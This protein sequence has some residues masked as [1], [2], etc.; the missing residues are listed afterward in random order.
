M[1]DRFRQAKNPNLSPKQRQQAIEEINEISGEGKSKASAQSRIDNLDRLMA[2]AKD[3]TATDADR[4]LAEMSTRMG[5]KQPKEKVRDAPATQAFPNSPTRQE[6]ETSARRAK[7]DP[8]AMPDSYYSDIPTFED[9]F[10]ETAQ[11][12]PSKAK[13]MAR[14]KLTSQANEAVATADKLHGLGHVDDAHALYSAIPKN[15]LPEHMKEYNP[16]YM[17]YGVAPNHW[18]V[19]PP[20]AHQHMHDTHKQ[21][22]AGQLDDHPD[23]KTIAPKVKALKV[24]KP[25]A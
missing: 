19:L 17:H 20:E 22:L 15:F 14:A 5:I 10:T 18:A 11:K 4:K 9:A 12:A 2:G 21:V 16:D 23:Y 6:L 13:A 1:L 8:K 3:K 25:S 7:K 24:P